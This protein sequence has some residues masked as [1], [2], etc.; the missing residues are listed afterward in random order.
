M[1][2]NASISMSILLPERQDRAHSRYSWHVV[3]GRVEHRRQHR[4]LPSG[5]VTFLLSDVEGSTRAWEVDAGVMSAALARHDELI[6]SCVQDHAGQVVRPRGEGDSRFAVF[7]RASDGVAA[8]HA[9]QM[10]LISENWPTDEPVRV[11][12][13]LHTGETEQRDEDYYGR[14]INR[15]ARIR[16]IAHGGQVLLSGITANLTRNL[17]PE[18]VRLRDLGEHHL[19]DI[20]EPEHIFQLVGP[21]LLADFP[22]PLSLYPPRH[23]LPKH[24][25]P[26]V[27]RSSEATALCELL[28]DPEVRVVTITGTGGIGKTRLAEHVAME[29]IGS[30]SD[31]VLRVALA[32]VREADDVL[33]AIGRVLGVRETG[34]MALSTRLADFLGPKS[35]LLVLD[36]F[37]Q[38]VAAAPDIAELVQ[39][40]PN[41]KLLA[42]SRGP[43]RVYSEH[44]MPLSPLTV[45]PQWIESAAQLEQYPAAK[46]LIDRA[47]AAQPGFEVGD[48][49]AM[50]IA[51]ICARLDGIPLAIELAAARIRVLSPE[52]L[53]ARLD[54]SLQILV[55][56]PRDKP[57]RQQTMR[58][59][60]EWSYQLLE[61]GPQGLLRELAVFV[62]GWSLE[63]AEA[64]ADSKTAVVNGLE[65]LI[66][67]GLV[68]EPLVIEGERRFRFF[69]AVREFAL[70][71]LGELGDLEPARRRHADYFVG[72][73]DRAAPFLEAGA[74]HSRWLGVLAI[75]RDNLRAA[76]H[77]CIE[78]DETE[79]ALRMGGAIW[80]Y[81]FLDGTEGHIDEWRTALLNLLERS[82]DR[83]RHTA[84]ALVGAGVLSSRLGDLVRA[85]ALYVDAL[86]LAREVQDANCIAAALHNLGWLAMRSG[87]LAGAQQLLRQAVAVARAHGER[88]REV[89]SLNVL[90]VLAEQ[91]DD[92]QTARLTYAEAVGTCEALG[93]VIG[94]ASALA[95]QG[96]AA[97]RAGELAQAARLCQTA[98]E[99]AGEYG[100]ATLAWAWVDLA[101]V[102][103]LQSQFI[104]AHALCLNAAGISDDTDYGHQ[105]QTS[106]LRGL[107]AIASA[108]DDPELAV[109]LFAT[110]A[111]TRPAS[112]GRRTA[113]FDDR[114]SN[115]WELAASSALDSHA[116]DAARSVGARLTVEHAVTLA[117][118][119]HLASTF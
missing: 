21:G 44:E 30:F 96:L 58:G 111:A 99:L 105:W 87:D 11:R 19:K 33:A 100:H 38:V 113:A 18:G 28:C 31:G 63:A 41:L 39:V 64:L 114:V 77:W 112:F 27:G 37:E 108:N 101:H 72:L 68:R 16:S 93:D 80:R 24:S 4:R 94:V 48:S 86:S 95:R 85:R 35:V 79:R 66:D 78:R 75:E 14:T 5:T 110:A 70:E 65:A 71:Q 6:E 43:L 60:I 103:F 98:V 15:C 115:E 69:E 36:N 23:N 107:A 102:R 13:A 59:A 53:L 51:S 49:Q 7:Q 12:I 22:P 8:A 52:D 57:L 106:A 40:C 20:G 54:H 55:G 84:R 90:G 97:A 118:Q 88:G 34:D 81:W 26:I 47:R 45:P 104:D 116:A 3:A 76:M 42:T 32:S 119:M 29:L 2:V 10:A 73:A 74:D 82:S 62:G 92:F 56:G 46:L 50:V 117:K 89:V 67:A 61:D 83:T 91:Q 109:T 1:D 25:T 9:I 17:L